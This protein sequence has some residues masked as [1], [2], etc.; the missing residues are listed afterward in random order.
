[1]KIKAGGLLKAIDCPL[2]LPDG[3]LIIYFV[4]NVTKGAL[5]SRTS[6]I[7]EAWERRHNGPSFVCHFVSN[8]LFCMSSVKGKDCHLT[9]EYIPSLPGARK[10]CREPLC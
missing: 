6:T 2:P 8:S 1:M 9:L 3:I 10:G 5:G 4:E 7:E